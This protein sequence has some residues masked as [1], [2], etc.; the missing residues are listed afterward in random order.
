V[1]TKTVTREVLS[2]AL[3]KKIKMNKTAVRITS[4]MAPSTE[5]V[6]KKKVNS[7]KNSARIPKNAKDSW[8]K[9]ELK[10]RLISCKPLRR[11]LNKL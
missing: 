11:T 9:S 10:L 7:W 1:A 5:L 8:I 4:A 2:H 6:K 3:F